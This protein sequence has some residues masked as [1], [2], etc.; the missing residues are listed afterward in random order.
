ME[1]GSSTDQKIGGCLWQLTEKSVITAAMVL[2][3]NVH[4][5]KLVLA[6][7]L[8][9]MQTLDDSWTSKVTVNHL[10]ELERKN[11]KSTYQFD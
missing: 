1:N 10:K 4:K 2:F 7:G 6:I 5:L 9:V 8:N 11:K 3:V